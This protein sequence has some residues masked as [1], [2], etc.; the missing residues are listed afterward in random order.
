MYEARRSRLTANST[1]RTEL[2][3]IVGRPICIRLY[4]KKIIFVAAKEEVMFSPRFVCLLVVLSLQQDYSKNL[5]TNFHD[6]SSEQDTV[7]LI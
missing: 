1:P 4:R 7:D 2:N 3:I 5:W 6:I